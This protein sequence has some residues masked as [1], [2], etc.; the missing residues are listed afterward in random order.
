MC[1][2]ELIWQDLDVYP[3]YQRD[4]NA[5]STDVRPDI[6]KLVMARAQAAQDAFASMVIDSVASQDKFIIDYPLVCLFLW[7]YVRLSL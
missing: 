7:P 2:S 1:V 5:N 3:G 4:K 6:D